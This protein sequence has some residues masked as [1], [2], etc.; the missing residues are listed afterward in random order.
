MTTYCNCTALVALQRFCEQLASVPRKSSVSRSGF[1]PSPHS[2]VHPAFLPAR[3][4]RLRGVRAAGRL[5][6]TQ[7]SPHLAFSFIISSRTRFL[8][9]PPPLSGQPTQNNERR[10]QDG[11]VGERPEVVYHVF[12]TLIFGSLTLLFD[13]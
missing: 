2:V 13:G 11:Y 10:P 9:F 6:Q 5:H 3:A 12:H 1:V 7:V 8:F 4:R